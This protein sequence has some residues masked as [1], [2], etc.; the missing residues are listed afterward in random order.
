MIVGDKPALMT[1]LWWAVSLWFHVTVL[2]IGDIHP[3]YFYF[4]DILRLGT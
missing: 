2:I 3:V 1:E 4:L